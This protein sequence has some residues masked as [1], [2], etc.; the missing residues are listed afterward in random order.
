MVN[1]RSVY[2]GQA[3]SASSS[4]PPTEPRI[5]SKDALVEVEAG[6]PRKK[7][8]GAAI[9]SIDRARRILGRGEAGPS[10]EVAGKV[11]WEPSICELCRLP[12]GTKDKPYQA[13]AMGDLP[14]GEASDP[15]VA[16]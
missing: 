15:L 14:E 16:R 5:G 13:R 9:E 11:R 3:S 4:C 8:G 2:G 1:L 6:R 12:A 7:S 10:R